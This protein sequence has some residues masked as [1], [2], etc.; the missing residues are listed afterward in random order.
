MDPWLG[1]YAINGGTELTEGEWGPLD[2]LNGANPEV[3]RV[4]SRLET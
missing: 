4:D 2:D 3:K 1:Q